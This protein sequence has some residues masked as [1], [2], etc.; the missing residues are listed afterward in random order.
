MRLHRASSA[1]A[2]VSLVSMIDVLMI[3]LVFFMVTSTYLDLRM[4]PVAK[5]DQSTPAEPAT[6]PVN[7][8][9]LLIRLGADGTPRVQGRPLTFPAL[10]AMLR[11]RLRV[12]PMLAVVVLPSGQADVQAL[13]ALLDTTTLAGVKQVRLLRL[14]PAP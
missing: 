1:T 2:P 14:E 8:P 9:P 3:M 11:E 4:V 13:V 12:D 7:L 5:A 10:D 6:S